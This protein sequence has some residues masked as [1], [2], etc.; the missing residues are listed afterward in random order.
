[1]DNIAVKFIYKRISDNLYRWAESSQH[2]RY[3]KNQLIIIL[4]LL[5]KHTPNW[6]KLEIRTTDISIEPETRSER[7]EYW[8]FCDEVKEK[9]W[10]W[11]Q[12]AMRK[13]LFVDFHRMWFIERYDK[14]L[15]KIAPFE[16]WQVKYVWLSKLWEDLVNARSLLEEYLIFSRW[17]DNLLWWYISILLELLTYNEYNIKYIDFYEYMF[18][19]SAIDLDCKY[20]FRINIDEAIDLIKSRRCLTKL[21]REWEISKLK[22]ILNPDIFYWDKTE[23]RDFW[24][25]KNKVQQAFYL[26]WQ[27]AYFEIYDKTKIILKVSNIWGEIFSLKWVKRSKTEK[28]K[29]FENHKISKNTWFELHHVVPLSWSKSKEQFELLDNWKNMLYIDA[30]SHAKITQQW[31]GYVIMDNKNDDI[32]LSNYSW[33]KIEL[34]ENEN[35]IYNKSQWNTIKN[36]NTRLLEI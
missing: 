12:D 14:N 21:Q 3:D 4:K 25:R 10:I 9:T 15:T 1:M 31:N 29:Y 33:N 20:S 6:K 28:D 11:T 23:K 27:S 19:I 8:N 13:N 5:N 22:W 26:L 18:F 34:E 36:Y 32:I 2:N 24:N 16:K 7:A 17:L 35:I 30:Y